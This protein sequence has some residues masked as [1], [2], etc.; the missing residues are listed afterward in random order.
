MQSL[1]VKWNKGTL[2][3]ETQ[4][5]KEEQVS[6][7]VIH[8]FGPG[9]YIREVS[10]LAGTLAIGHHH[11]SEHV[12]ILLKGRA[13][14]LHEDGSTW[15]IEA[16]FF[17][18]AQPG[19]KI[20]YF[21]EASVW[22]NIFATEETDVDALEKQYL[23]KS[24]VFMETI[25]G[26]DTLQVIKD[27]EDYLLAI[28]EFGYTESTAREI[29]ER[30]DDAVAL[31]EGSYKFQVGDSKLEG[32]GLFATADI[33]L[34]DIIAPASIKGKRTIAG[35]YTNHA[36]EP[37]A[38]MIRYAN[39]DV[40]LEAIQTIKGNEGGFLGDEIT[41]DYRQVLALKEDMLCQL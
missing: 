9:I 29:S 31:P 13:T 11:T 3:L 32:K 33:Y 8:R 20:A 26:Y 35:R 34:G 16:P 10:F 41:V 40:S 38:V 4:L 23:V 14:M 5:L 30:T 24:P 27:Q 15:D 1:E 25:K 37:N 21:Y 39:G 2:A 17:Y 28:D 12:N 22:Q 19:R 7:P 36:K 18:I 6:V